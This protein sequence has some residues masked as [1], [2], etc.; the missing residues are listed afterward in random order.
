MVFSD[1]VE[2][3]IM[4]PKAD[5]VTFIDKYVLELV[6]H[7]WATIDVSDKAISKRQR[8]CVR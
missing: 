4:W 1:P 6:M 3:I 7:C 8:I 5:I 2:E